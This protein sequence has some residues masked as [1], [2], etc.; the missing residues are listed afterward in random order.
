MIDAVVFIIWTFQYLMRLAR[1]C[2]FTPQKLGFLGN[3]SPKVGC[4]INES[5]KGTPMR[6]SASF[7]L[8]SVKMW[9]T[10]WPVNE[11][12]KKGGIN[13]KNFRDNSPICPEA[14]NERISTKFC[15]ALALVDVI[16]CAKFFSDRFCGWS[17]MTGSHWLRRRLL[18][19]GWRDCAACY[20]SMVRLRPSCLGYGQATQFNKSHI[21]QQQW[22]LQRPK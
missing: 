1:K 14:P 10:V 19:Q 20:S 17:N 4:N 18:T 9:S 22:R 2:L 7:E 21:A 8:L 12:L 3:L 11:L 15:T 16:T 6:E 13:K 5:Q